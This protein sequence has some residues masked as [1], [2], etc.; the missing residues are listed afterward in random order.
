MS[1]TRP[2]FR[3]PWPGTTGP[4]PTASA[5]TPFAESLV[6]L[7][8]ATSSPP[9][10]ARAGPAAAHRRASQLRG[11]LKDSKWTANPM[12]ERQIRIARGFRIPSDQRP[13]AALLAAWD[14]A[15]IDH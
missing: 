8:G 6:E 15:S 12:L 1:S 10:R 14:V 11:H 9:Y 7:T 5:R 3:A 2:S 4:G 13:R